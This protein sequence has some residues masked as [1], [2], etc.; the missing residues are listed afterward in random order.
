MPVHRGE[1]GMAIATIVVLLILVAV[2]IIMGR[3]R[4]LPELMLDQRSVTETNLRRISDAL[5]QYATLNRRLPCPAS[6]TSDSG[7]AEPDSANPTCSAAGGT[8]PWRSLALDRKTALDGWGRKISYRVFSGSTGFTQT[9]GVDMTNCNKHSNLQATTKLE[10]GTTSP[11]PDYNSVD[12]STGACRSVINPSGLPQIN[13]KPTYFGKFFEGKGLEG[14][15]QDNNVVPST[16]IAKDRFAFVL[17]SHG[18]RSAGAY[19]AQ[20]IV[21]QDVEA[22]S[23][24]RELLNVSQTPGPSGPYGVG[25]PSGPEVLHSSS[26]FFDDIVH[27]MSIGEL[28]GKAGLAERVWDDPKPIVDAAQAAL[29][30]PPPPP[31]LTTASQS[32]DA[33]AIAA[34]G[35]NTSQF[36]TGLGTLNFGSF[37]VTALGD[38]ARNVGF[39]RNTGA[40][41]GSI[42]TGSNSETTATMNRATN[43]GLRFQFTQAGRYLGV[44][45]SR[46]GDQSGE[47]E[48]V[49]F[50]F[51]I[52]GS[53]VRVTKVACRTG[54]GRVN[55]TINPGG[56]FDQVTIEPRLTEYFNFNSTLIVAAIA[57]CPSTNPTCDAPGAIA[58]EN[59][60]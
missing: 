14:R 1:Q 18:V 55:F 25:A 12:P 51:V 19:T 27:Y 17:I 7:D 15:D 40:G 3:S 44:T 35:G 48:R 9:N 30:P 58:S 45:L 22:P 21:Q 53:T 20:G 26:A 34:A 16:G 52:G 54:D 39:D 38:T 42:G 36:N 46:F 4:F 32:F 50:D 47:R 41:I 56:D 2:A 24:A 23:G 5:V 10:Y 57:T 43:E 29:N 28:I 6:T 33:A 11:Y 8:V 49:S 13:V 37:T 59:C 31:P 60:P